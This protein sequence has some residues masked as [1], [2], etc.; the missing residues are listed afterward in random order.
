MINKDD[1]IQIECLV[2]DW[3][4]KEDYNVPAHV[5]TLIFNMHNVVFWERKEY[6]RGCGGCRSRV[7]NK[8]KSWYF[9]NKDEY[10]KHYELS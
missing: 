5:I 9:E 10:H 2:N 7:W 3:N 4:G 1:F 6:S 8:L